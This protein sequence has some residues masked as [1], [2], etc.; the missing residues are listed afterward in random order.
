MLNDN[1]KFDFRT[2]LESIKE[3]EEGKEES[4]IAYESKLRSLVIQTIEEFPELVE[5]LEMITTRIVREVLENTEVMK[6]KAQGL[7]PKF[8]KS[9]FFGPGRGRA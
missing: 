5:D 3:D 9:K 1:K 7:T 6:M 2:L 4:R 8:S